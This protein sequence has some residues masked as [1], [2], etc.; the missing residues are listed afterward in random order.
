MIS[1]VENMVP[2][3][4]LFASGTAGIKTSGRSDVA[5]IEAP[6]GATAAAMFTRNRVAAAP[7]LVGREHLAASG[8]RLRAIVVN[9]G[10]ANCATGAGGRRAAEET[11]T[12]L[13]A[14]LGCAPEEILPS[15]TGIIGVP[16]PVEKLIG[17]LP[18][19]LDTRGAEPTNLIDVARAIMTTDTKLKLSSL[20]IQIGNHT[21]SVVGVAKGAGM[22][23]PD[24]ATMLVYLFT[25]AAASPALLERVLHGAVAETFN[26]ISIDGDTS[27]N[28]T[29]VLMASGAA[30][31][32]ASDDEKEFSQ[33]VTMVCASLAE[34]I[35]A[36]GEG[37]K[38]LVTL[39]V[40][41]ADSTPDAVLIARTIAHSLLVKTAWAGAD[42]NWGRML[43]AAG[44]AG[45]AIDAHTIDIW[46]GSQ[47]VCANGGAVGFDEKK[48]HE[49]M[50]APA[51]EISIRVGGGPGSSRVLTTDL[52]AEYVHINADY[53][54]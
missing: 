37:V 54:T 6:E 41:G 2:R 22:I 29:V 36:D 18:R 47:Q 25:D 9:S 45:V 1:H 30:D 21:A 40:E 14:L 50:S 20:Q 4:F 46:I 49:E 38:H 51:Y 53:S 28:D 23:H 3:G 5:I 12:E 24:M 48:A 16:L 31:L 7:V 27:T 11:C 15:S 34:Q 26:C 39:R 33:A 10:N 8:G 35:V 42:P 43:A 19:V 13:A 17:A 44:R 52:T 32:C